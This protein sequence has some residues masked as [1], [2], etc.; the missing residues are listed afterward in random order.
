MMNKLTRGHWTWL[1]DSEN[2]FH[3]YVDDEELKPTFA[4]MEIFCHALHMLDI[5]DDLAAVS[6]SCEEHTKFRDYLLD[7]YITRAR[8]LSEL[9]HKGE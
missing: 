3:I 8:W 5:I 2:R 9:I 6:L 7:S 4:D 1:L